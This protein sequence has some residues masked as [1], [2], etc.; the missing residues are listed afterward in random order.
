MIISA[1][2]ALRLTNGNIQQTD[3]FLLQQEMYNIQRE[4][5]K[6]IRKG[7]FNTQLTYLLTVDATSQL[8]VAGYVVTT[9][10]YGTVI[11]WD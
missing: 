4:V 5:T 8:T 7:R 9:N 10:Q 1:S 6:A 3:A 2:E 11:A